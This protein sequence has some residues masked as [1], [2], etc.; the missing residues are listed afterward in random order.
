M[1]ARARDAEMSVEQALTDPA[2][3]QTHGEPDARRTSIDQAAEQML[4]LITG[5]V[6]AVCVPATALIDDLQAAMRN[7]QKRGDKHKAEIDQFRIDANAALQGVGVMRD[8]VQRIVGILGK[9]DEV[10]STVTHIRRK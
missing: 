1:N 6:D 2:G 10:P 7:M 5:S 4:S 8:G 9:D 3:I